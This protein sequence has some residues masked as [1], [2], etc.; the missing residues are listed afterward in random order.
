MND[1]ELLKELKEELIGKRFRNA[2]GNIYIVDNVVICSDTMR[3]KI[4]YHSEG[5]KDLIWVKDL[6]EFIG[7][8]SK[9]KCP[10]ILK[11]YIFE[12]G[13]SYD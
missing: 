11:E 2:R 9:I 1:L 6:N 4:V 13:G 5:D 3:F 10:R 7:K 8:T 12:M